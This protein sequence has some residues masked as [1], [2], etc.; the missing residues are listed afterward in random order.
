ML[1]AIRPIPTVSGETTGPDDEPQ[2]G[3]EESIRVDERGENCFLYLFLP[4]DGNKGV[5]KPDRST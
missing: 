1:R 4:A 3:Q 5:L 2:L